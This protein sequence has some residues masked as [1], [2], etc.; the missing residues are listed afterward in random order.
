MKKVKILDDKLIIQAAH[1]FYRMCK[2]E[3]RYPNRIRLEYSK[4]ND[5]YVS[6]G[7]Q[8]GEVIRVYLIA[9]SIY[10]DINGSIFHQKIYK[11]RLQMR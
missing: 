5:R 11:D 10:L 7:N 6:L 1:F 4:V 2:Q 3:K 8:R 9:K